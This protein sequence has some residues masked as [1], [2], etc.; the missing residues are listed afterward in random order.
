MAFAMAAFALDPVWALLAMYASAWAFLP[1]YLIWGVFMT[2][3]NIAQSL[4]LTKPTG[5]PADR[6]RLITMYN[7]AYGLAAGLAPLVAGTL[8]T[9]MDARASARE[10][11]ST[12][13]A[14]TIVLRLATIPVLLRLPAASAASVRHIS[15]VYL[16]LV[17]QQT[18]RGTR[19]V[20]SVIR[21]PVRALSRLVARAG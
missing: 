4:A 20:G 12:L 6:I 3:W 2:G 15:T 8:L 14:T 13:F 18:I 16:R 7:V 9:W 17:K 5:H 1:S 10:A 11:F 19:R 21:T